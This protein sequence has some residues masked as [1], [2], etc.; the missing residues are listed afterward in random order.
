MRG[1]RVTSSSMSVSSS[2]MTATITWTLRA[3]RVLR[4]AR[5][6]ALSPSSTLQWVRAGAR[7]RECAFFLCLC[8]H[9][10]SHRIGPCLALGGEHVPT[11]SLELS[12]YM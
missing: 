6:V 2:K 4:A 1:A 5:Y 10:P 7:A 12:P 11:A 3:L 8:P 9:S